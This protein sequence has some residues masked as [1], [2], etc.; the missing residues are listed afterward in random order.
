MPTQP[1]AFLTPKR[2][3]NGNLRT[4]ISAASTPK[5]F[6]AITKNLLRIFAE[7][8]PTM[9]PTADVQVPDFSGV[10]FPT[11]MTAAAKKEIIE[12]MALQYAASWATESMR[13]STPKISFKD[14]ETQHANDV[15]PIADPIKDTQNSF[16]SGLFQF[17]RAREQF[18]GWDS[19]TAPSRHFDS[20][21]GCRIVREI[22]CLC[23][24]KTT[25]RQYDRQCAHLHA[26]AKILARSDA[27]VFAVTNHRTVPRSSSLN[28]P[29]KENK[30]LAK[31]SNRTKAY[32]I[33][34]EGLTD[35]TIDN[36]LKPKD[37]YESKLS[38]VHLSSPS[39]QPGVHPFTRNAQ[40]RL[41]D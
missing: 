6:P 14:I 1:Q 15:K 25:V 4:K 33:L 9:T 20:I 28:M 22:L 18:R 37:V 3:K 5:T 12:K 34:K 29:T 36:T 2:K 10:K 21:F 24:G 23:R 41:R 8:A 35:G 13:K 38:S 40:T 31:W 39:Y 32:N 17:R 19:V 7:D 11:D 16:L 27:I 26:R 30:P